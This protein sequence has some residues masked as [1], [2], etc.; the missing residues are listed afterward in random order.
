MAPPSP[1]A[2][3]TASVNRL[4]KEEA[5]YHREMES[6]KKR[7]E[8]LEAEIAEGIEDEDGNREYILRQERQALEETK[9]VLPNLKKK[10]SEA[11]A[12]LERLLDEEGRKG[13]ESDVA[14]ITA[15][16]EAISHAMTAVRE[17]S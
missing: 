9:K 15:A 6:Q 13:T 1:L 17:I 16:K 14:Q 10:I 4:V 2:V 5:S 7:I 3:A 11:V 12:N 8:K